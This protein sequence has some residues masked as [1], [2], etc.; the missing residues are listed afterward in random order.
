MTLND[1]LTGERRVAGRRAILEHE[2]VN[3]Q[4]VFLGK[5]REKTLDHPHKSG[6]CTDRFS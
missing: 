1:P 3:G 6:A 2:L 5:Y 4:K